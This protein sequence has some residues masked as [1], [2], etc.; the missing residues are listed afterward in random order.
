ML[1]PLHDNVVLELEPVEK[2]TES[3]IILTGDVKEKPSIAKVLAVG[4]GKIVDGKLVPLA[5]K[6]GQKVVFKKYTTTDFKFKEKE[7]LIISEKDI[8]AIV[9]EE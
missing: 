7:Y 9:E 1:K 5:V 6:V 2:K 4:E 3:G 8:L